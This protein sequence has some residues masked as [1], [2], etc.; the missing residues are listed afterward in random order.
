MNRG[1]PV[2]CAS[3][4]LLAAA[5][6]P[7]IPFDRANVPEPL[8]DMNSP[9]S[10]PWLACALAL[11]VL[12]C[13][14][15]GPRRGGTVVIAAGSDL[16]F[17]NPLVSVDNWTNEVLR[18]ALFTPL[19]EYGPDLSFQPGLAESWELEGD[20]AVVFRLRRDV[21]WHD[22]RST[23]AHDVLFTYQRAQDPATAFPNAAYFSH[24]TGGEVVD[25]Y[26]VRFTFEPHAD[27]LAGWPFT[28]PAP[29][30]LLDTV[31][32]EQLRQTPFNAAPVG[33]GPF[34]FVS[35]RANDR[36]VFEANPD[37]P[38]GL[39]G[40][41]LVDRLV[42]RIVPDNA[43]QVTE[44]RVGEV[45][46]ALQPRPDQAR[47]LAARAGIRAVYKPSRRFTFVAWNGLRAPLDDPRVRRALALAIDRG[48]ILQGLRDGLGEPGVGPVMPFHWAWN[49]ALEPLPFDPDSARVLLA[50][51]GIR[52]ADEDG[53]LDLP[54]GQP[55]AVELKLPASND[56]LRDVGEAIRNDLA[57]VGVQATSR[58][59]ELNT[60]YGDVTSPE[61]R[62]DA[63][64]LGWTGDFRLDLW[65]IFHS[66]AMDGIYQLSSFA[67]PEVDSLLDAAGREVDRAQAAPAWRRIQEILLEKQPWTVIYYETEALLA[68]DRVQNLSMDI[69]G[70]LVNVADWW[71]ET[72][73]SGDDEAAS[74]VTR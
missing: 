59:V 46:L 11:S 71:I 35:R 61:R 68:R 14:E 60:L 66:E 69:R 62:F 49:D 9:K 20:T 30:H 39:G 50:A 37:Y 3:G 72:T 47:E 41:P 48:E 57:A 15:T 34:R 74:P 51:A 42:W 4:R 70:A 45:D 19:I 21:R 8:S 64:L 5:P 67:D 63:A 16:D 24:W 73:P 43:A 36:W 65:D 25:S 27:P 56:Y 17:A 13:G 52:D 54:D 53:T 58:P 28:P 23:T 29:R 40:P 12:A 10:A 33:N 26:T 44:L 32:P 22:G 55:F 18:Y 6:D 38:A 1:A 7:H 31:P 2:G